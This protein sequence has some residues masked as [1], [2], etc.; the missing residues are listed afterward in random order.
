MRSGV[1]VAAVLEH[2]REQLLG[3]L[4]G[5]QLELVLLGSRQ[6]QAR[7]ELEQRGDQDE[8]LGRRLEVEL[9]LLFDVL[10]I[11]DHD[12]AQLDLGERDLLAQHHGHQQVEGPG[13]DVEIEIELGGSHS[14]NTRRP[15]GGRI[16]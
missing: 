9:A 1:A 5:R 10:E 3:R 12:L 8:E 6:Q 11:G 4:L 2:P 13:E 7:L 16:R 14:K 15:S